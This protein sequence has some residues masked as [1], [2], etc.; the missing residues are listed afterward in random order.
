MVGNNLGQFLLDIVGF[1]GL[2]AD[3]GQH[4]GSLVQVS[5]LH[6]V[7]RRLREDKKTTSENQGPGKL[8][9][10]GDSIGARVVP[11]LGAIV[12]TGGQHETNGDAELVARNKSTTDLARSNLRHIQDD[13]SRNETDT[14]TGN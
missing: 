10:D 12:D 4:I 3:T 7:T 8:Q 11:V 6:K 2:T 14:E 5:L 9:S 1:N 13:D